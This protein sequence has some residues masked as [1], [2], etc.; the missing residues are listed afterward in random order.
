VTNRVPAAR[1]G[2]GA[3]CGR[4]GHALFDGEPMALTEETFDRVVAHSDLPVA[5]DF[6]AAWCAP[7][8][9]MAPQFALAARRL[10]PRVRCAKLDTEAAPG[11]AARFSIRSIPTVVVFRGGQEVARR[12]GALDA[13]T[14][15]A[16]LGSL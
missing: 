7:C 4:C 13:R 16:W 15:E 11:I 14:L 9:A 1:L 5:V 6:W 8:R 3:R 2:D 10:E 12:S